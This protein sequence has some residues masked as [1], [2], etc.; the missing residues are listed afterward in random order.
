VERSRAWS[1]LGRFSTSSSENALQQAAGSAFGVQFNFGD[2]LL[3]SSKDPFRDAV[4]LPCAATALYNVIKFANLL[5]GR[6]ILIR[7]AGAI[8]GIRMRH[9]SKD[10]L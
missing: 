5:V 9:Q 2:W 7:P 4:G 3:S 6:G 10:V 1:G 8:Y